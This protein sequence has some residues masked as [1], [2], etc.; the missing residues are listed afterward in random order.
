MQDLEVE[1]GLAESKV[2]DLL[3]QSGSN[4]EMV[5]KQLA[6]KANLEKLKLQAEQHVEELKVTVTTKT[7]ESEKLVA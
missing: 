2:A 4:E 7:S 5:T 1:K 6:D 3:S